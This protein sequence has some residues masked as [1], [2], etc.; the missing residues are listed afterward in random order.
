MLSYINILSPHSDDNEKDRE[1]QLLNAE[2]IPMNRTYLTFWQKFF[3]LHYKMLF[4]SITSMTVDS[5]M[6]SSEP[7]EWPF[8]TRGVAYWVSTKSNV[9]LF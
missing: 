6:Y 5:H 3:E 4:T 9:S 7:Y 8:L 1:R 2:M